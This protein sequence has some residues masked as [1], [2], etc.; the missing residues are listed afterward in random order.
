MFALTAPLTG[1]WQWTCHEDLVEISEGYLCC[2]GLCV[3]VAEHL[4][5]RTMADAINNN[6][7]GTVTLHPKAHNS[8][9]LPQVSKFYM[10]DFGSS[11][12]FEIFLA[13]PQLSHWHLT[14]Y[15]CCLNC[16][17]LLPFVIHTN[18][19]RFNSSQLHQLILVS[20]PSYLI[21]TVFRHGLE[22]KTD[23]C[24]YYIEGTSNMIRIVIMETI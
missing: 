20:Y 7:K 19:Q 3:S 8:A 18:I 5:Q 23:D 1:P 11:L 4:G 13:S 24:L 12:C 22:E 16:S 2:S 17:I 14:L 15:S 9:S 6:L 21:R 10:A